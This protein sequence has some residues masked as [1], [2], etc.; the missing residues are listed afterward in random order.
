MSVN[1]DLASL[2]VQ[3]AQISQLR[4]ENVF[5]AVSFERVARVLE[6]LAEDVCD[7]AKQRRL[8][9]LAGV[10]EHSRRI[11]EE[12]VRTGQS[13][14]HQ[15]MLASIPLGLLGL[16]RIPG[17]GPKTAAQLWKERGITS[18]AEL[19]TAIEAGKLAGLRGI[20]EK[21]IAAITE[22]LQ[23]SVTSQDRHGLPDVQ[24]ITRQLLAALG[25][26]PGVKDLA[27]A[28]SLRRQRETVGDLDLLCT[29]R[30]TQG[31]AEI[32]AAFSRLPLVERIIACGAT[33]TSVIVARGLQV[34][35]RVV[36][37]ASLGAAL[38][39]FTGSKAHNVKI[40]GLAQDR[41]LTL[42][43]WGLYPAEAFAAAPRKAGEAPA[44]ESVAGRTEADVYEA[45]G[46]AWVEPELR[47]GRG[48]VE[49][50]ASRALPRL[51][52]R[53]DIQGEL[54]CHTVASD[55]RNSILEMGEAALARG[56]KFLAITDHSASSVIANGL[57]AE[58]LRAHIRTIRDAQKRLA[59]LTLLAGSEV[60]ILVD[61]RLDYDD[62]LLAEL[63]IVIASPHA[64]LRQDRQK[65]TDRLLRA[66]DNPHVNIIGHP[67]GRLIGG[68]SGLDL[69]LPR[70]FKAAAD[71]GV[72]MEINA[73]WPRLDLR[74]THARAA[75][76]AGVKITINTDAHA[77]AAFD[78][79]E[80]GIAVARRAWLTAP[81]VINT[82][83]LA[84]LQRFLSSKK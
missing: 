53:A 17:L 63:D 80:L 57:S 79:M 58:R 72:A 67:T 2:F 38:I 1:Q 56:Y 62:A 46:L 6:S 59:G 28:G 71:A 55:G 36:P 8:A 45:L 43:E 54:H 15:E 49:A 37:E 16:L 12:F 41:G 50:A 7:L 65:A 68:R 70:V 64:S 34:D 21:K 9:E 84:Q 26:L 44:L 42:N 77:T 75:R 69:D 11:I 82:W 48:E 76:D 73:G 47:E 14:E 66:I 60:D 22:G 78:E 74:D 39:Y 10:G 83:P 5:K 52:T 30:S 29:T 25:N 31:A 33:K 24:A 13:Q 18:T 19:A 61:G 20:G 27:V 32:C 51:I 23:A 40:R 35:L 81:D 4:G 3:M